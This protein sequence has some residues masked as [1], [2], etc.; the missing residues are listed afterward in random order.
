MT[1]PLEWLPSY[2]ERAQS[3]KLGALVDALVELRLDHRF[4]AED[5]TL[6]DVATRSVKI[7]TLVNEISSRE[8]SRTEVDTSPVR[9]VKSLKGFI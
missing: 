1:K 6:S 7:E 9:K 4:P 2:I 5:E 8:T 3:L